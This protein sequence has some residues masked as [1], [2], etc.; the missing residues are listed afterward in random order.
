MPPA[1]RPAKR[2]RCGSFAQL[3]RMFAVRQNNGCHA[4][5]NGRSHRQAKQH[6]QHVPLLGSQAGARAVSLPPAPALLRV[7]A[8]GG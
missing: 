5:A 2:G 7:V 4:E 6:C 1:Q 3:S 8:G